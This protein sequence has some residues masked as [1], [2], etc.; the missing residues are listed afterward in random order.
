VVQARGQAP[1]R[2]GAPY[3]NVYAFVFRFAGERIAEVTEY[4]D[5]AHLA[6]AFGVP[7]ERAAL[8][9]AMDL[10][11]WE[12]YREIVRTGRG[13]ELIETSGLTVL[14]SPNGNFF[15]NAIMI[16][17]AVEVDVVLAAA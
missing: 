6:Q 4:L 5:T 10:N 16:R 8:L 3:R 9:A 1:L 11:C 15:H 17:D 14:R 13:G 12:M 2:S 7:S